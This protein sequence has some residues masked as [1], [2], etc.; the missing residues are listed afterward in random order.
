MLH[1]TRICSQ[2]GKLTRVKNLFLLLDLVPQINQTVSI[3]RDESEVLARQPFRFFGKIQKLGMDW[4]L[5]IIDLFCDTIKA[6]VELL[7]ELPKCLFN[8][9]TDSS[10][11][12]LI[13]SCL[14]ILQ[15]LDC[16]LEAIYVSCSLFLFKFHIILNGNDFSLNF[17]CVFLHIMEVF[18]SV[19][20]RIFFVGLQSNKAAFLFESFKH[21]CKLRIVFRHQ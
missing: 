17:F 3:E 5:K 12:K 9:K 13:F 1:K 14:L 7:F 16:L 20:E 10:I 4:L 18:L 6:L 8:V 15:L 21:V 2:E 11:V 19:S